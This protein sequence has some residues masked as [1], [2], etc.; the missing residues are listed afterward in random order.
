MQL[1][2][3]SDG[4]RC[5][6]PVCTATGL[7][8]GVAL[9]SSEII[10]QCVAT[11]AA[12]SLL[13]LS[14]LL[15]DTLVHAPTMGAICGTLAVFF[16]WGASVTA[17]LGTG[18]GGA[19]IRPW[20]DSPLN[21]SMPL[22]LMMP[23]VFHLNEFL[24]SALFHP[25]ELN[26]RAFLLTPVPMGLYSVAVIAGMLEFWIEMILGK[27]HVL[28]YFVCSL[29]VLVGFVLSVSGLALR[30][31]GEFTAQSNFTHLVANRK[32]STHKLV[33][34]GVYQICRH[35]GYAG[36]FLYTVF[37]QVLMLNPICFILYIFADYKFFSGRIPGEEQSLINFFGQEYIDYARRV[38]CGVPMCSEL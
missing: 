12:A 10:G 30:S 19:A 14:N 29:F 28:P 32:V 1:D 8:I 27:Q 6:F 3:P 38:P 15:R 24:F 11:L 23:P 18:Q 21:F 31:A 20:G 16:G 2:D 35:P 34:D 33:T 4:L 7:A 5:L 22:F 17:L 9:G 13:A 25:D 36:Y 37:T 26:F